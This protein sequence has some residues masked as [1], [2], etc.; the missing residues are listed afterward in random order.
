VKPLQPPAPA[1][2]LLKLLGPQRNAEALAGDLL[3]EFREG[4]SRAWYWRQVLAAIRWRS[5]LLVFVF[6]AGY[7]WYLAGS[8]ASRPFATVVVTAI[9]L[10][11]FY[12][13]G[14]LSTAKKIVVGVVIL[15]LGVLLF[16]YLP[17]FRNTYYWSC[18]PMIVCNFVFH[19]EYQSQPSFKI[20]YRELLF[21][22]LQ[23]ERS[24]LISQLE[25]TTS[26]ETDPE[27]RQAYEHSLEALRL[28]SGESRQCEEES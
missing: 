15:I 25:R 12:L 17:D 21:G 26:E 9:L 22:D 7:A 3:E 5:N 23:A 20:S 16:C 18:V 11:S 6:V 1:T 2:W 24:R 27:R 14:M 10:A 19:R 8:S 4:R 28:K 13:P